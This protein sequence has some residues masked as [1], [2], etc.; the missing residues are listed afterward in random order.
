M[1]LQAFKVL[2]K[3]DTPDASLT[4][5]L[6]ALWKAG[7]GDWHG[8]H[9]VVQDDPGKDAAWVHA[10]LHREEGDLSNAGYWYQRAGRPVAKGSLEGEWEEIVR[11]LL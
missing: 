9:A 11:M 8:A 6:L 2:L 10:Y 4:G 7:K 1:D 5:P 3:K